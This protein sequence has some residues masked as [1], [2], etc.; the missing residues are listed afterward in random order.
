MK[1]DR[2]Q[3]RRLHILTSPKRP[4][5]FM[6]MADDAAPEPLRVIPT[7]RARS[8]WAHPSRSGLSAAS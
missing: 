5:V 4:D 3:T 7:P 1:W 6:G 8:Y 2:Q